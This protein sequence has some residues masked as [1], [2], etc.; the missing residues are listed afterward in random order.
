[1]NE[2]FKVKLQHESGKLTAR[3]RILKLLDEKSFVEMYGFFENDNSGDGVICGYGTIDNRPVYIY[4]QDIT[5]LNGA[6]G[7]NNIKRIYSIFDMAVKNGTIVIGL[8]DSLGAKIDDGIEMIAGMG[9]LINKQVSVSGVIPQISAVM[10]S[11][12][13]SATYSLAMSDFIF[14][15]DNSKI[16]SSNYRSLEKG[17]NSI[18]DKEFG[19]TDFNAIKSGIAHFVADSEEECLNEIRKLVSFLPD[20]NLTDS[21]IIVNDD[22][23]RVSPKLNSIINEE[24]ASY[25]IRDILKEISDNND[26]L[27]I[28]KTF[29][30]NIV[31]GFARLGGRAVGIVA[32]QQTVKNG[33]LNID[34]ADKAGRFV[35]F[36]DAFNIPIITFID[37]E[38]YVAS[39]EQEE[40]GLIRHGAKLFY[41]Y[42]EATVP[43]INI[44]IGKAYGSSLIAMGCFAKDVMFAWP[45]AEI[46]ITSPK[47]AASILYSQEINSADTRQNKIDE[48]K[49]NIATPYEAAKAGIIE[50]IIEPSITRQKIISALEIFISKRENKPVKK[51]GNIPC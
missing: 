5:S 35:R 39:A 24:N 19:G 43:K 13:G 8:W 2:D 1:M 41:A 11:C 10:G 38:G 23:N 42:S 29:A 50:D 26:L 14:M 33:L 20:N 16:A 34:G 15:V 30:P 28:H 47:T 3:E 22:L 32:N 48:Y 9:E 21:D 36:C 4:S 44:I 27:E 31:T 51:H 46:A 7:K 18:S 12:F 40:R 25:D 17:T 6:L 37:S 49:E 45:T